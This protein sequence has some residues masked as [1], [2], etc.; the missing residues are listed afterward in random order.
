ML[1]Q[2]RNTVFT[3]SENWMVAKQERKRNKNKKKK[4]QKKKKKPHKKI[5]KTSKS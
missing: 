1:N 2:G 3:V 4:K 5:E